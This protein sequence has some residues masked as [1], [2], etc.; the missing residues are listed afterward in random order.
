MP[1]KEGSSQEVISQN[2]RELVDSGYEQDQAVAI[3]MSK[4]G[5][6]NRDAIGDDMP[7]PFQPSETEDISDP[8]VVSLGDDE[9]QV[10]DSETG[11]GFIVMRKGKQVKVGGRS[12][13][14]RDANDP[15]IV[16]GAPDNL[17]AYNPASRKPGALNR[18]ASNNPSPVL[19]S[20]RVGDQGAILR[21]MNANN[22]RFWGNG[23]SGRRGR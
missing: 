16:D 17:D 5:K 10:L 6:S 8:R 7:N 15:E 22:R 13:R 12:K 18:A 14:S 11:D 4:A 20:S 1:L 19:N 23:G 9:E 3:A 21:N 2:I